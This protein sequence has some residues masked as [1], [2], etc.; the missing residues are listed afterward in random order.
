MAQL[1]PLN[2]DLLL[3]HPPAFFDFRNRRDVYFPFLSTSGSVP[4]TPLYDYFPL[5]FKSLQYYL[6]ERGHRVTLLN[7][8]TLLLRYPQLDFAAV[9]AALDICLLG[10]DLHWMIHAQGGLAVA[11]SFKELR[12]EVPVVFGGFSATIYAE[13]LIQYPFVDLVLRGYDTHLPLDRLLEAL[14]SGEG[15][16]RVPNLVWKDR[17]G[18]A[19]DN[20]YT[21]RPPAY[22]YYIDWSNQ[23]RQSARGTLAIS[24]IITLTNVGCNFTCNW[25]GGSRDAFRL[26]HGVEKPVISKSHA[27]IRS[28]FDSLNSI[29]GLSQYHYYPVS[30]Y[31]ETGDRLEEF[32]GIVSASNFKSVSYEQHGLPG[33]EV[34]RAMARSNPRTTITLSPDSHDRRVARLAGRGVFSNEALEA[35][36]ERALEFGIAQVDLWYM[37]GLPGQDAASVQGTVEYCGHLLNKFRGAR[38]NPL[39]CPLIP[40]LDPGSMIFREPERFGYRLVHRTLE[41]HRRAAERASM[42]QW[43]NYETRWLSREALVVEGYRAVMA[44]MQMKIETGFLPAGPAAKFIEWVDDALRFLKTVDAADCLPDPADREREL[45]LLGDEIE[46]RN[47]MIFFDGVMNQSFPI[48]RK[49]GGRWF[50]EHGWDAAVLDAYSVR[51]A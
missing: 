13:E 5:G 9:A 14:K 48:N 6:T 37:V 31:N 2:A 40:N 32:L 10:I 29:D 27:V 12:P 19:V 46:K 17:S 50:D 22:D 44:L 43:I 21:H 16:E 35:W 18:R 23:P 25:C 15:L 36:I 28:E 26:T 41:E 34:L 47:R 45:E 1:P 4:T 38:V 8:G 30:T 7:L 51:A 49:I 24:E 33:D 20:G 3:L 39:I 11:R 42:I